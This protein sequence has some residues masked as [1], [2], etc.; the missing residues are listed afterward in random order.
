MQIT[1]FFSVGN[2]NM[3]Y[4]FMP[5]NKF[6]DDYQSLWN[7]KSVQLIEKVVTLANSYILDLKILKLKL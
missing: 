3:N 5:R 7:Y 6:K 2:K 1:F 4:F